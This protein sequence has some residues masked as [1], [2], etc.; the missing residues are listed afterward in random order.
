MVRTLIQKLQASEDGASLSAFRVLFGVLL[1][2][3]AFRYLAKGW[4]RD[5]FVEARFRFTFFGFEW[6]EPLPGPAMYGLFVV[7]G[8]LGVAVAVGFFARLSLGLYAA[9]FLYVFLLDATHYLNHHYLLLL[10]AGLL[11]LSPCDA[12]FAVRPQAPPMAPSVFRWLLRAQLAVVYLF[13][14]LAKL[15][16][17]WLLRGEPLT[18]WMRESG[19]RA[20]IHDPAVFEW[21]GR[22]ASLAAFGLVL[23]APLLLLLRRTRPFVFFALAVFHAGTG[24]LLPLGIFP[25]LAVAALTSFLEPSWP[26]RLLPARFFSTRS[27]AGPSSVSRLALA[28]FAVHLFI[29]LAVPLRHHLYP[30]PVVWTEEGFRFAWHLRLI[31]KRGTVKFL[32]RELDTGVEHHV[33]PLEELSEKQAGRM[34]GRPEYYVQYARHLRQR[35]GGRVAVFVEDRVSLNGRPMQPLVDSSV[36]LSAV[37]PSWRPQHFILPAPE[38]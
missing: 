2:V 1:S 16:S 3:S 26:R 31:E 20:F 34:V 35:L 14:G 25:F 23:S 32:V 29:Q 37:E 30:G 11:A 6:L 36:D 38:L 5:Y 28:L 22:A 24:L 15:Q 21:L 10:L 12:F 7:L 13:S 33:D 19:L 27:V 18:S 4:V 17:D 9:L 8:L